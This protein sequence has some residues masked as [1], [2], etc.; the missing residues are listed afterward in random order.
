MLV[1]TITMDGR[2]RFRSHTGL[3]YHD[4]TTADTYGL[5]TTGT[6]A[7]VTAILDKK[8]WL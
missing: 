3:G 5:N 4:V 6:L 7:A 1:L 8:G 2:T